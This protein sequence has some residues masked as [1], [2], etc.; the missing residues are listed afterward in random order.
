MLRLGGWG[1]GGAEATGYVSWPEQ[2]HSRAQP[3]SLSL[4]CCPRGLAPNPN[5]QGEEKPDKTTCH[6]LAGARAPSG[7]SKPRRGEARKHDQLRLAR[8]SWVG[9]PPRMVKDTTNLDPSASSTRE[10]PTGRQLPEL[11]L[12]PVVGRR[13]PWAKRLRRRPGGASP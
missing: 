2:S 7:R 4:L 9:G 5:V 10:C 11:E 8:R 6:S 3:S 1:D 12:L 13:R